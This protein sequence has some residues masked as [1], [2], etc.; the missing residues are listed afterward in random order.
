MKFLVLGCILVFALLFTGCVEQA[1][2]ELGTCM[3]TCG[4]ICEAAKENDINMQGY[5]NI[6]LI[7]QIGGTKI[8]CSCPC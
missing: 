3:E 7:K 2:N 1:V 8:E 5:N 6:G 4:K